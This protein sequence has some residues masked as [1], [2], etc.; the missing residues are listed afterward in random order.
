MK[1]ESRE[2]Y[3][4]KNTT[5]FA[6]DSLGTKLIALFLVPLYTE[7]MSTEDFGIADIVTTIAMIV[8]PLIT[9]NIGESVMRFALDK[10]ADHNKIMSIGVTMAGISVTV[11]TLIMPICMMFPKLRHLAVYVY[12]YCISQ[13]LHTIGTCYLRGKEKLLNFAICNILMSVSAA[14]LN[15]IFLLGFKM[16]MEGYFLAFILS[17]FIGALYSCIAGEV[18]QSL[19]YF[20]LDKQLLKEM[21]K[22]SIVLVPN[23]LMWWIMNVSDRI[24]VIAMVGAAANG[25]YAISYKIPSMLSTISRIFVQA[26][27]Y[28]AI[29]ENESEDR[30]AFNNNMFDRMVNFLL[31]VTSGLLLIMKPFLKIYVAADFYPAWRYTAPLLIGFFFMSLGSFLS[32]CYTVHKDSKGFLYSGMAGAIINVT[33]NFALIPII[34]VQGAAIA[35][36]FSYFAVFAYRVRDTRKYI[37]FHVF[38]KNYIIGVITMILMGF[39][40]FIES[41]Y[42]YLIGGVLFVFILFITR[43]FLKDLLK[44]G[45]SILK[46]LK[47]RK[48]GSAQ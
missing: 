15:I 16:G 44:T 12:V 9:L 45:T 41:W 2:K 27:S 40:M 7:A 47:S 17:H 43:D 21:V 29:H 1:K 34:G 8:V 28:S 14:V 36:C 19:K 30:D 13:G 20:S 23:S 6:L 10:D 35:T 33:F 38:R 3:L 37:V 4:V 22:F 18:F 42:S 25:I 31:I 32:T 39:S 11:G 48:T 26:W 24:M 5:L 46:K